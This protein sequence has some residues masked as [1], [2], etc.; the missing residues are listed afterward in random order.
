MPLIPLGILEKA[1][2]FVWSPRGYSYGAWAREVMDGIGYGAML[3]FGG[4]FGGGI[5]AKL[6]CVVPEKVKKA[7]LIVPAGIH[8]ALPISSAK[9]MI[10]L[11][12]YLVTKKDV[13]LEKTVLYMAL[14]R[15]VL[16]QHT[17]DTVKDS[18]DNVKIKIGMPANVAA[19]K[20]SRCH[21][22]TLVIAGEKDCL[23]PAKKV[24][25]KA[26]KMI[27]DCQTHVWNDSGHIHI[28]PQAEKEFIV[29]F[30]KQ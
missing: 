30:L 8:N 9:M 18:F 25:P 13:Y 19:Q 26:R 12:K 22:P 3:C 11:M 21:S 29:H 23:F 4:S 5:L 24:L 14:H 17:R 1:R 20:L 2:R 28:L 6:M 10:P 27:S 7:V 15:D 16:D